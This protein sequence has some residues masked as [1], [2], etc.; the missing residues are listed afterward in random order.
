MLILQLYFICVKQSLQ[1]GLQYWHWLLVM[2]TLPTSGE[3]LG[4]KLDCRDMVLGT[5]YKLIFVLL[6]FPILEKNQYSLTNLCDEN[7]LPHLTK[8][9][10]PSNQY[11]YVIC[12]LP[13]SFSDRNFP[14]FKPLSGVYKS[15]TCVKGPSNIDE[16]LLTLML[17]DGATWK[18]ATCW[19]VLS[20]RTCLSLLLYFRNHNELNQAKRWMETKNLDIFIGEVIMRCRH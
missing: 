10:V 11:P 9:L 12:G 16:T 6:L 20:A 18:W 8:K 2:A 17:A 5:S 19:I 4:E 3:N 1:K 15:F 14:I 13:E 7:T